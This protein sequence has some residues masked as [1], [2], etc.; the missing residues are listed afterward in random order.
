[1]ALRRR[2]PQPLDAPRVNVAELTAL[3]TREMLVGNGDVRVVALRPTGY[4]HLL[5]LPHRDELVEGVVDGGKAELWQTSPCPV[6]DL[7]ALK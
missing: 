7:A 3:H 4:E 1:M 6:V 2:Q 5:Q